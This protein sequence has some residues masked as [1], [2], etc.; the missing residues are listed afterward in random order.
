MQPKGWCH[1]ENAINIPE[2][3]L[4]LQLLEDLHHESLLDTTADSAEIWLA[5]SPPHDTSSKAD[6]TALSNSL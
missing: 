2:N 1:D 5:D 6:L 4:M 3:A